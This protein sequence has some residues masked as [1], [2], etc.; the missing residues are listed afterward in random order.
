[1]KNNTLLKCFVLLIAALF[2][3]PIAKAEKCDYAKRS[4]ASKIAKNVSAS[5][6]IKQDDS[7]NYYFEITVYNIVDGIYVSI[8]ETMGKN[9]RGTTQDVFPNE[10]DDN[11]SYTFRSYDIY[12][13]SKY[14]FKVGELNTACT[15][16]L[17][18]ITLTKPKY[19]EFSELE[20]CGFYGV[21]DVLY[22]QK[23]ITSDIKLTEEGVL[24]KIRQL[25][26]KSLNDVTTKCISCEENEKIRQKNERFYKIRKYLIIGLSIGIGADVILIIFLYIKIKKEII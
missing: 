1:M 24:E 13:V 22:C 18:T 10:T 7:G 3:I 12:N 6:E 19:N 20:E 4:E 26:K 9:S 2:I 5:Y 15:G 23:W 25:R 8:S 16:T 21:E 17:R 14:T 11:N